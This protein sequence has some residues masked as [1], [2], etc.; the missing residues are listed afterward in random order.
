M[1]TYINKITCNKTQDK[2]M[3][4][5]LNCY[6]VYEIELKSLTISEDF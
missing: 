3:A 5:R 1:E 6:E 4:H 2:A